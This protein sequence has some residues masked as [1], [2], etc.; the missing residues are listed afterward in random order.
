MKRYDNDRL[1]RPEI[2]GL[3]L[4]FPLMPCCRQQ[5]KSWLARC[6]ENTHKRAQRNKAPERIHGGDEGNAD[7]RK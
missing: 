2:D 3:S 1:Y 4:F 6:L 5:N 7:A